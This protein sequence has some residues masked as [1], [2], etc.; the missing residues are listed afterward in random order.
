MLFNR[1]TTYHLERPRPAASAP[2]DPVAPKVQ[3][4]TSKI[5]ELLRHADALLKKGEADSA[6]VLIKEARSLDP[7]HPYGEAMEER[8]LR[9]IAERQQREKAAKAPPASA[10]NAPTPEQPLPPPPKA[11][12]PATPADPV[13]EVPI[14]SGRSGRPIVLLI[15]DDEMLRSALEEAIDRGGYEAIGVGTSEEALVLLHRL[16]PDA[17]ICDVNLETSGFGGFTLFERVQAFDHL[18]RVPFMFLTG[19]HDDVLLR[20]GKELG[21]DDYLRKPISEADLLSVLRGKLRRYRRLTSIST[22]EAEHVA[23]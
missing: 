15:D 22:G 9:W 4:S 8:T 13:K 20:T 19:L 12:I 17:I 21:A 3:D 1:R 10:A 23:A 18:R 5:N 6:L 16:V 2:A 14:R 11:S 7:S